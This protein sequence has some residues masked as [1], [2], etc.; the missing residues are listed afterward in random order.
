[1]AFFKSGKNRIVDIKEGETP[2][3]RA[4]GKTK[5][6]RPWHEKFNDLLAKAVA[7]VFIFCMAVMVGLTVFTALRYSRVFPSLGLVVFV[8]QVILLIVLCFIFLRI[9]RKR[10]KF[11][12]KLKKACAENGYKIKYCRSFFKSLRYAK[13][14]SVDMIIRAGGYTYYVKMFGAQKKLSDV[15]FCENGEMIYK[16]LRIKNDLTLVFERKTKTKTF[17]VSFPKVAEGE[18]A[19]KVIVL[20]P[21]PLNIYTKKANGD[22]EI[23]GNHA[24][25][26]GYTVFSG[27]GFIEHIK[28]NA[29]LEKSQSSG[30]EH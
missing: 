19:V 3:Y 25:M 9:P 18:K 10:V 23:S 8:G 5:V 14:E 11:L 28:R 2:M 7:L 1:M 22:V 17:K 24:E 6:V 4:Y 20:N 21:V 26:F 16:K 15:I 30:I 29:E 27:S 12:S 13:D